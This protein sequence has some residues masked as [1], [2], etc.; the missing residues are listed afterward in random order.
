MDAAEQKTS[1][2]GY[3]E[4]VR[5]DFGLALLFLRLPSDFWFPVCS[6]A[7]LG[8]V[9]LAALTFLSASGC[10]GCMRAQLLVFDVKYFY[11]YDTMISGS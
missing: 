9:F 4:T 8:F 3:R 11:C 5:S 6:S 7:S 2:V 10:V 1:I